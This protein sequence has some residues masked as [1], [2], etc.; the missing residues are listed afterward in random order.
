MNK[1]LIIALI[2]VAALLVFTGLVNFIDHGR[3][4][5]NDITSILSG[6]GFGL[7]VIFK[8]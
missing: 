8:K 2:V 7:L 1:T 6:I 5:A 4:S 3:L